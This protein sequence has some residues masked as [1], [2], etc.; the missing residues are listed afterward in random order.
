MIETGKKSS[1]AGYRMSDDSKI[2][3]NIDNNY[4]LRPV[5]LLTDNAKV[6]LKKRYLRRG[7]DG[8]PIETIEEMAI[9]HGPC[10]LKQV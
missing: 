1:D 9:H 7:D 2:V 10:F 6:V 8:N 4:H 3:A 5:N